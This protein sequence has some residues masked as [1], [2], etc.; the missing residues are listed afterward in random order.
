MET[1]GVSI[2]A[3]TPLESVCGAMILSARL[4]DYQD[5]FF[6]VF[7]NTLRGTS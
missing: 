7:D 6:T 1:I 3:S 2:V 4:F 5:W